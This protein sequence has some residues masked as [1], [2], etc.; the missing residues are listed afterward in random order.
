MKMRRNTALKSVWLSSF[1]LLANTMS[2]GFTDLLAV[3]AT[4]RFKLPSCVGLGSSG[5]YC[6][7]I[8]TAL[9]QTTGLIPSPSIVTDED[10]SL[11]WED[12]HLDMIRKW[13]TAAESLIHGRASGLDAAVCTYVELLLLVMK[14]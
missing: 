4:V 8:A 10:G 6:V 3:K 2:D 12:Q 7:C 14:T 13:A 1:A 5:A 9:L 11:T